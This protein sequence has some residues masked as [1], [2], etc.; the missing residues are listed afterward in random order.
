MHLRNGEVYSDGFMTVGVDLPCATV[1]RVRLRDP[2]FESQSADLIFRQFIC[3]GLCMGNAQGASRQSNLS[4]G[5]DS[6]FF[7]LD[8]FLDG[9]LTSLS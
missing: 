6:M 7:L 9:F 1:A 3:C 5:C 2:S 4:P 8:F